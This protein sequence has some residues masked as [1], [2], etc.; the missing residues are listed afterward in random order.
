MGGL[1]IAALLLS[2]YLWGGSFDVGAGSQPVRIRPVANRTIS[3][4][5]PFASDSLSTLPLRDIQAV[6]GEWCAMGSIPRRR[7]GSALAGPPRSYP[8]SRIGEPLP[9]AATSEQSGAELLVFLKVPLE[10]V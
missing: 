1:R 10:G 9:A 8:D 5:G 2:T 3:R 7:P 6:K 4:P